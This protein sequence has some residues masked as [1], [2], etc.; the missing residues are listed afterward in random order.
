MARIDDDGYA[1]IKKLTETQMALVKDFL[2]R[3]LKVSK[4]ELGATHLAKHIVD[5]GN[6][7]PIKQKYHVRSSAVMDEM[8]K[9]IDKLIEQKLVEP[10]NS[11]WSSPNVMARKSNGTYHYCIDLREMNLATKKDAYPLPPKMKI[12]DKL[13][14]ANYS[15]TIDLDQAFH[16]VPLA[17]T[18]KYSQ[19]SEFSRF[20]RLVSTLYIKFCDHRRAPFSIVQYINYGKNKKK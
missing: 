18:S 13:Q 20:S 11:A 5:V 3:E 10:S 2:K 4:Q 12:L 16:Q 14:K 1:A 15:N 17:S 7:P 19:T 6:H 8:N 9:L